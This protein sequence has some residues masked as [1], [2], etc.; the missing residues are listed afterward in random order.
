M[1]SCCTKSF[2]A[3]DKLAFL[4]HASSVAENGRKTPAPILKPHLRL[5]YLWALAKN[6][7]N[8]RALAE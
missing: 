6:V 7:G 8:Y 2:L 1:E 4:A 3:K 5:F